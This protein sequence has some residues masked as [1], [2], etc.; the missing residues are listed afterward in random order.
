M[1]ASALGANQG[2]R[3]GST[4]GAAAPAL[5]GAGPWGIAAGGVL[6][7]AGG[8][9]LGGSDWETEEVGYE[10]GVTAGKVQAQ[11]Y[12]KQT[13]DGGLLSGDDSRTQR[14]PVEDQL[15]QDLQLT[16]ESVQDETA[17]LAESLGFAT[18]A[19]DDFSRVPEKI[20]GEMSGEELMRTFEER[21]GDAAAHAVMP[22]YSLRDAGESAAETLERVADSMQ[23]LSDMPQE[24]QPSGLNLQ[25]LEGDVPTAYEAIEQT[26]RDLLGYGEGKIRDAD[27]R[28]GYWT[29]ELSAKNATDLDNFAERLLEQSVHFGQPT[30]G[31]NE[32]ARPEEVRQHVESLYDVVERLGNVADLSAEYTEGSGRD[33]R[34]VSLQGREVYEQALADIEDQGYVRDEIAD[35]LGEGLEGFREEFGTWAE[36]LSELGSDAAKKLAEQ[37]QAFEEAD[38]LMEELGGEDK[39]KESMGRFYELMWSESER[40]QQQLERDR[41]ALERAFGEMDRDVP[42]TREQFRQLASGLDVSTKRGRELYAQLVEM[43]PAFDRVRSEEEQLAEERKEAAREIEQE[44]EGILDS[45]LQSLDATGQIRA[46]ELEELDESNRAL[47]IRQWALEDE[48]NALQEAHQER[49]DQI[50]EEHQAIQDAWSETQRVIERQQSS[51]EGIADAADQ[52][53]RDIGGSGPQRRG[54][55]RDYLQGLSS[56]DLADDPERVQQALRDVSQIDESR[57]GSEVDLQRERVQTAQLVRGVGQDAR[58]EIDYLDD[59][60]Q[61]QRETVEEVLGLDSRVRGVDR[62]VDRL[63]RTVA[64]YSGSMNRTLDEQIAHMDEQHQQELEQL[65]SQHMQ[66]LEQNQAGVDQI[67]SRLGDLSGVM[68]SGLSELAEKLDIDLQTDS[69]SGGGSSDSGSD[70]GGSSGGSSDSGG[71]SGRVGNSDIEDWIRG[72]GG[73]E[74]RAARAIA[75]SMSGGIPTPIK[76]KYAPFPEWTASDLKGRAK[77]GSIADAYGFD[78]PEFA[79]GGVVYGDTIARLGEGQHPEAIVPMPNG[80]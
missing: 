56:D 44:R 9:L 46:R 23:Y 24:A 38:A 70:G 67:T 55:A 73:A 45:Y 61:E 11:E 47:Q 80:G 68:D 15:A 57:Y 27:R 1:G 34:N 26:Y 75:A 65:N 35:A 5:M 25:A 41:K 28:I 29:E 66:W 53:I 79:S 22:L 51:L 78:I 10:I 52:A 2:G 71:S 74:E 16:F 7:A 64:S 63:D 14:S 33:S 6:G 3:M 59:L 13:R 36:A 12:K 20:E 31:T 77:P 37:V 43:A 48:R 19:I 30:G 72:G 39:A 76:D 42:E 60:L 49:V 21:F 17:D 4:L 18:N 40:E 69:G 50:R 62:S 8:D 54:E 32:D 58:S